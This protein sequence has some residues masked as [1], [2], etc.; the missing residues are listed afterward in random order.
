MAI[1]DEKNNFEI[2]QVVKVKG[3]QWYIAEK[4]NIVG[5]N[6]TK[7]FVYRLKS[8]AGEALITP[9]KVSKLPRPKPIIGHPFSQKLLNQAYRYTL[10]ND[11]L[12]LACL[13][14]ARVIPENYQL[15]PVLMAIKQQ[16]RVRLL[17]ADGVGLGKTVESLLIVSELLN[18]EIVERVL[19]ICPAN[20]REQWKNTLKRFFNLDAVII[21]ST[22]RRKLE[23]QMMVDQNVWNYYDI[24]IVSA[25]YLKQ[26]YV[27]GEVIQYPWDLAII[28]EAHNL[29]MPHNYYRKKEIFQDYNQK[30]LIK[31]D[32]IKKHIVMMNAHYQKLNE[33][34]KEKGI[35]NY[36]EN[37]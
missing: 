17:I 31:E 5:E 6:E 18:K 9:M 8:I 12:A 23:S 13:R 21:D 10:R 26:I 7:T 28:D 4:R 14:N 16:E 15:V 2:G 32:L 11:S 29:C 24:V 22:S 36:L 20:I 35:N 30:R 34:I 19:I 37:K 1:R 3:R 25:D 33:R 27:L